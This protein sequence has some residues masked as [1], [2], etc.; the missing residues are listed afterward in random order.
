MYN[1][2]EFVPELFLIGSDGCD[3]AF[4]FQKDTLIYVQV[5]FIGMSFDEVEPMGNNFD[6]FINQL[7]NLNC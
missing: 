2:N 5:P 4:A 7:M 1:A 3:T 6:E